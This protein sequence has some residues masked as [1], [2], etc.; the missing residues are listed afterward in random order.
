MITDPRNLA[1]PMT[2]EGY[3]TWVPGEEI[4]RYDCTLPVD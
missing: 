1:E 4:K 2:I 3:W